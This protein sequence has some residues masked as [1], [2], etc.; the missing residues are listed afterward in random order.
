MIRCLAYIEQAEAFMRAARFLTVLSILLLFFV[1][2]ASAQKSRKPIPR[3][4]PRPTPTAVSPVVA[5][6]KLQVSN[7]LYNV[8][9]FVDR[10]GPI[11]VV[12]ED[13][14]KEARTG[15][16]KKE[17]VAANEENKKKVIAAIRGLRD[18]LVAVETDF[19]TKPQLSQY[20][21]KIQGISSLSAQSEDRAIAGQFVASKDPLRQIALKLNDTLAVLPGP[22]IPGASTTPTQNRT[23][24][25]ANSTPNQNAPIPG[26]N[27]GKN[28]TVSTSTAPMSTS[29]REPSLG[30]TTAEVL[31]TSWGKPIDKRSS[32]SPSGT[33]EVWVYSGNRTLYF[34]NGI[35]TNI[36]Q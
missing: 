16:L 28:S 34:Y 26:S 6:A 3:A 29:K 24:P 4:T 23:V 30:M 1:L 15:K 14:D 8:N 27:S 9:V 2:S 13:A 21:P 5:V 19:R 11:A 20:L 33:T 32:G 25:A 35:L 36:R 12:I 10:M 7:Q 22:A 17:A 31:L 18:G